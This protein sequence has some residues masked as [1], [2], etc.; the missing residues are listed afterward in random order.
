[1]YTAMVTSI[2]KHSLRQLWQSFYISH[3]YGDIH[4]DTLNPNKKNLVLNLILYFTPDKYV[5]QL[6]TIVIYS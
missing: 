2:L 6:T 1:M 4:E 5:T 3:T